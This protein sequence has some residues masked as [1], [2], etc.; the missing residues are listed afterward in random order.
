MV[1]R[2]SSPSRFP[3]RLPFAAAALALAS[4]LAG[5]TGATGLTEMTGL[6]FA[7]HVR[8]CDGFDVALSVFNGAS[9]KELRARV[10]APGIDH[11]L[12]FVVEKSGES[13]VLVGFTPLGTK[14]FTLERNGDDVKIE[15]LVGAALTVSPRNMMADVLAMSLPSSCATSPDAVSTA[16]YDGWKVDDTCHNSR[17]QLRHFH[18]ADAK[19]G[20]PP[21]IEIEYRENEIVV[22]QKKCNYISRYVL[23]TMARPAATPAT[24]TTTTATP[25]A[26]APAG[27]A[28]PVAPATSGSTPKPATSKPSATKKTKKKPS[29]PLPPAAAPAAPAAPSPP[30]TGTSDP[31][32]K[33][34]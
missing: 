10:L 26:A 21:E 23:Q 12:P 11:D 29:A 32:P 2:P 4:G 28:A 7:P 3:R 15:N 25:A 18:R 13:L 31:Q 27:T 5:C 9:R 33:P 22:R 1:H 8:D 17:P 30:V 24:G 6:M 19:E 34:N 16:A 20:A 14:S